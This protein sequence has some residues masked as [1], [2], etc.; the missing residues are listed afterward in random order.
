MMNLHRRGFLSGLT[1][2]FAAPVVLPASS[3]MPLRGVRLLLPS[4]PSLRLVSNARSIEIMAPNGVLDGLDTTNP[5]DLFK[6]MYRL[7]LKVPRIDRAFAPDMRFEATKE[8]AE[9]AVIQAIR[10]FPVLIEAVNPTFPGCMM[11]RGIPIE[12]M[13]A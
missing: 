11:F 7:M 8:V 9:Y 3:L 2:A 1:A 13:A 10:N 5:P 6:V 4:M 12:V